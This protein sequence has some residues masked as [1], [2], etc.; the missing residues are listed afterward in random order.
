[1][2]GGFYSWKENWTATTARTHKVWINVGMYDGSI[3][4]N[5]LQLICNW[6]LHDSYL[7]LSHPG[8]SAWLRQPSLCCQVLS[9]FFSPAALQ[10]QVIGKPSQGLAAGKSSLICQAVL[11]S[12]LWW[13]GGGGQTESYR[14]HMLTALP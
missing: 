8:T 2:H 13:R 1:M 5:N 11:N 4:G 6:D 7:L 3:V 9:S 10:T 14:Q 12:T